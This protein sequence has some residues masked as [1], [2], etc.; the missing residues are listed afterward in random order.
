MVYTEATK[1][2]TYTY[3]EKNRELIR[4][5]NREYVKRYRNKIKQVKIYS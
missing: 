4:E 2:A 1:R 3:R 5:K